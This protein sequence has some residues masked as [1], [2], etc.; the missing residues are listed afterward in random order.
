MSDTAPERRRDYSAHGE[1]LKALETELRIVAGETAQC[2]T[3]LHDIGNHVA[4]LVAASE[5]AEEAHE[6]LARQIEQLGDK[7]E[8]R[9]EQ[10]DRRDDD[11]FNAVGSRLVTVEKRLGVYDAQDAETARETDR[12]HNRR[13]MLHAALIGLA[14]ALVASLVASLVPLLFKH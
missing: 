2:R 5:Q 7:I 8:G 1:R 14:S 13:A 9:I 3:R 4:V 10:H 11:R 12:R 6:K